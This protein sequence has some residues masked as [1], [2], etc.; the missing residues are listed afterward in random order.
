[1]R[2]PSVNV[3]SDTAI[4]T[5][6]RFPLAICSAITA[7]VTGIS[8]VHLPYDA[9]GLRTDHYNMI[10]TG[11]LAMLLFIAIS[12][13][14]ERK[15]LK[16]VPFFALRI[17]GIILMVLYYFSLPSQFMVISF[18]RFVLFAI[19]LHLGIAVIP[20]LLKNELN[21]FWQ[22]NKTLFLRFL[23]AALYT[24]VFYLGLILAIFAVD[25]L[26]R[27][28]VDGDI[29]ADLWLLLIGIF[30]TWFFLSGVPKDYSALEQK[31]DYPKGLKLFTQYV[32]LPLICIYLLILYA[33]LCRII[34]TGG[35]PQ[36]WVA[37]LVT[38]FSVA[39]ILS[40]LLIYPVRNN[41]GNK[42]I[43][44]FSRFFY[45]ALFPLIVLLFLAIRKRIIDYGITEQRYLVLAIALWLLLIAL[46]FLLSKKKN[47]KVI[48]LSLA[49][50][51]LLVSFGPWGAFNISLKSQEN[52]FEKLLVKNDLL[53]NGKVI[54]ARDSIP[55]H[56]NKQ[57][58]SIINYLMEVHGYTTLQPYFT[59]NL[60][61]LFKPQ[62]TNIKVYDYEKSNRLHT[63]MNIPLI[64]E[65][66]MEP[67][68]ETD[69][70]KNYYTQSTYSVNNIGQVDLFIANYTVPNYPLEKNN[71]GKYFFGEASLQVCFDPA[72]NQFIISDSKKN[73]DSLKVDAS[74]LLKK[75]E[76][77]PSAG[78]Q[79]DP[80]LLTLA[81]SNH[82]IKATIIFENISFE[83]NKEIS[84][85]NFTTNIFISYR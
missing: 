84:N 62:Q 18:T 41:E 21:G 17:A 63:L 22:Y 47:I 53:V 33:Y 11:Y 9:D 71:C 27:V 55:F 68:A 35:W 2:F 67:G 69:R 59:Q 42:W 29:Y 75:L 45:F 44:L 74:V 13:W 43:G 30:N 48:P 65:W 81:D 25:Q 52:R 14:G 46:Y 78:M 64:S 40:L 7:T 37:Y 70:F 76:N 15:R 56:E 24:I 39:G 3:L 79:M 80:A 60:D 4:A 6:K 31:S 82:V 49:L 10:M 28:N 83:K 1:M 58:S 51:A 23:T 26:F 5:F 19:A 61:S 34:I 36:G 77:N 66:Q 38:G 50:V 85:L 57:L 32:L 16:P 73:A 8:L 12:I 72:K 20:Y 54:P